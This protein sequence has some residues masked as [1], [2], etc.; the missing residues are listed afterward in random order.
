MPELKA[1]IGQEVV[2]GLKEIT[3]GL[4]HRLTAQLDKVFM[5]MNMPG[6]AFSTNPT[7]TTSS[8]LPTPPSGMDV[9][10]SQQEQLPVIGSKI[11]EDKSGPSWSSFPLEKLPHSGTLPSSL[12]T[13][14]SL[15]QWNAGHHPP[16]HHIPVSN[17]V[18][19]TREPSSP[20][21]LHALSRLSPGKRKGLHGDNPAAPKKKRKATHETHHL[22][23]ANPEAVRENAVQREDGHKLEHS[24][25]VPQ[26]STIRWKAL[27]KPTP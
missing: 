20:L 1:V 16:H 23:S 13:P 27:Y 4:E 26:Y 18:D 19:R 9:D 7:Y 11:G 15:G 8:L 25:S 21:G 22:H 3:H 24:G 10:A 5:S 6:V 17:P 2:P 12:L 14:I